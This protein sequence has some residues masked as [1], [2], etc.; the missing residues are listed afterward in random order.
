MFFAVRRAGDHCSKYPK[1]DLRERLV[2][3]CVSVT[4][5]AFGHWSVLTLRGQQS[6]SYTKA[7]IQAQCAASTL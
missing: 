5:T 6:S 7:S 1:R 4:R 2:N 3:S